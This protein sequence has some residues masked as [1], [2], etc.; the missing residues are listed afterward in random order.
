MNKIMYIITFII[1]LFILSLILGPYQY[2]QEVNLGN[3]FYY[4][5]SHKHILGDVDIPPR[6]LEYNLNDEF[7]IVKQLPKKYHDAI[8]DDKEYIYLNGRDKLYY[9]IIDKTNQEVIGPL[10]S[11]DFEK[12]IVEK[13]I[14]LKFKK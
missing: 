5:G 1:L 13:E 3:D 7:I 4:Y 10:D 12:L 14:N 2:S 9:W 8:Y 6:V 11:L